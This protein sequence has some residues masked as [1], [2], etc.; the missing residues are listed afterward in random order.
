METFQVEQGVLGVV[1]N[2]QEYAV[3]KGDGPVSITPGVR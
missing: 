3:T 2:G 1:K